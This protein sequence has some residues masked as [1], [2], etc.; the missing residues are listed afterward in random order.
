MKTPH[1]QILL[2]RHTE[3]KKSTT[4][5]VATS[6]GSE[7]RPWRRHESIQLDDAGGGGTVLKY[8]GPTRSTVI[9]GQLRSDPAV[10]RTV[11]ATVNWLLMRPLLPRND[12]LPG[13]GD[14]CDTVAKEKPIL[15]HHYMLQPQRER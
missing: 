15:R 5:F 9:G 8:R 11:R 2:T 10:L 7:S 4:R 14:H 6:A 12:H 1:H 13:D 3:S